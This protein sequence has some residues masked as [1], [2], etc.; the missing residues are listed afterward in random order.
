MPLEVESRHVVATIIAG[1]LDSRT[2]SPSSSSLY[3][4]F[5]LLSPFIMVLVDRSKRFETVCRASRTVLICAKE[6]GYN[7]DEE[8]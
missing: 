6:R 4:P 2:V 7:Y 5:L 8:Q 1:T 3:V